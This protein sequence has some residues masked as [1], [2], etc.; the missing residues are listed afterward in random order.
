MLSVAAVVA[1]ALLWLGL[2]FGTGLLAERHP[3]VF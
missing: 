1:A 2:L 3:G